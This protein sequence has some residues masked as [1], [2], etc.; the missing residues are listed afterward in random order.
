MSGHGLHLRPGD[1]VPH[2]TVMDAAGRKVSYRDAV[3][4]RRELVLVTLPRASTSSQD[5]L[6]RAA[7]WCPA[8]ERQE[9]ACVITDESVDGIPPCRFVVADRWGE[10]VA[11]QALDA[12]AA[13]PSLEQVLEWVGYVQ[14]QCPECQGETR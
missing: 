12:P 5:L 1:L 9:V 14:R 6:R 2:F 4:Q 11:V 7:D 13:L 10:I 3:W 8:L